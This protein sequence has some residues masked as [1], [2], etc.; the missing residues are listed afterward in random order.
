MY[1]NKKKFSYIYILLKK[2]N[3]HLLPP[4]GVAQAQG[5]VG[6]TPGLALTAR[7]NNVLLREWFGSSAL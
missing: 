1:T 7:Y 5:L 6:F 3:F 4:W 2:K